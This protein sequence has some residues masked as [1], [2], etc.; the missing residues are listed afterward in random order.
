MSSQWSSLLIEKLNGQIDGSKK[1]RLLNRLISK[2]VILY[3]A[4][5]A[6]ESLINVKTEI[7]ANQLAYLAST[8]CLKRISNAGPKGKEMFLWFSKMK[9]LLFVNQ[10]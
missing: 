10:K 5:L 7:K 8:R 1:L 6:G 3:R 9:K 4:L 2:T